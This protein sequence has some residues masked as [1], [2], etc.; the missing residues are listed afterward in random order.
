[1]DAGPWVVAHQEDHL[2][3]E[4][5]VL[6]ADTEGSVG[7]SVEPDLPQVG[8]G[9]KAGRLGGGRLRLARQLGGTYGSG[10]AHDS[11]GGEERGESN[12]DGVRRLD[13]RE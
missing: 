2:G 9:L 12:H 8:A 10:G 4:V 6:N 3:A 7:S 13:S 1:V 11:E 5:A